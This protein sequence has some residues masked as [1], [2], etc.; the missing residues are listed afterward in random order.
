MSSVALIIFRTLLA[1]QVKCIHNEQLKQ[2]KQTNIVNRVYSHKMHSSVVYEILL[3]K[4]QFV[5][6]NLSVNAMV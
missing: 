3:I 4:F 2:T 6:V 5:T 1:H